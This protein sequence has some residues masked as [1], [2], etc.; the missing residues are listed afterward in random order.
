MTYADGSR[1][2]QIGHNSNKK[3][4]ENK[5]R[6]LY[7]HPK[8]GIQ[9]CLDWQEDTDSIY[10]FGSGGSDSSDNYEPSNKSKRR[11]RVS[12]ESNKSDKKK[13]TPPSHSKSKSNALDNYG[14]INTRSREKKEDP[15]EEQIRKLLEES[16]KTFKEEEAM[17]VNLE[18]TNSI[19][20]YNTN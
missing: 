12:Q 19:K 16:E 4:Q 20:Q 17:R 14:F 2:K 13:S 6:L 11:K 15:E 9:K 18:C 8:I 10:T 3:Q 7:T 5:T 1:M